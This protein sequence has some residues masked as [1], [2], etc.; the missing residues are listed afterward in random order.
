MGEQISITAI[1]EYEDASSRAI[2]FGVANGYN[3]SKL[4]L[5]DAN[6]K[7]I[8]IVSHSKGEAIGVFVSGGAGVSQNAHAQINGGLLNVDVRGDSNGK[9]VSGIHVANNT[10]NETMPDNGA[11]LEINA[12]KTIIKSNGIG[13]SAY[14]NG[15]LKVKGD[16]AVEAETAVS[17][18]GYSKIEINKDKQN[19]VQLRAMWN[20]LTLKSPVIRPSRPMLPSIC[21]MRILI[22]RAI[23]SRAVN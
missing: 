6:T 1:N 7:T 13:V 17:A 2:E 19:T 22:C 15:T 8:D 5:G 14:S 23:S 11:Y 4:V 16:L 18:R 12:D 9:L 3:Q 21:P 20:S 10:A